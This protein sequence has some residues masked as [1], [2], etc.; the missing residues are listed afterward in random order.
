MT[1]ISTLLFCVCCFQA[2]AQTDSLKAIEEISAF[3]KK[4]NEE[5]KNR[6]KSPLESY[7]FSKFEGHDF[8]PINLDYRVNAKLTV[9]EGTPFFGM[10]TSSSRLSTERI[11]GYITF[12]LA[13]KEFRLPVYQSKDLM[14]TKE[15]ADYLFF[16][17][18]DQTNSNSTYAGGR[19]IDLRI[20]HE[21]DNIVVD[22]N[23]AYNPYC[24]YSSKYSCPIVPADNEMDIEVPAGIR[25]KEKGKRIL[26]DLAQNDSLIFKNVD[27]EA[28]Y[29]GGYDALAKFLRKHLTY[30]KAAVKKK[31]YGIVYVQFVV[32]PL[33]SIVQVRT[34]RGISKEC[35]AEAERVISL[36]PNWKPGE[37]NGKKVF[38]RFVL[39]ISFIG[40]P[41][42]NKS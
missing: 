10:K 2:S 29:P 17:F 25:Y 41:G 38:V 28:E 4:L 33:G 14:D 24:A 5:Y 31:V 26:P 40:R 27:V 12:N 15:Y 18:T 3:R 19:Y 32:T 20:P 22:F 37:L 39:P 34:I 16:P 9:T 21:G 36:M 30:P 11:Y 35:D 23:M 8:F 42:W 1:R 6:E 7:E 13:E